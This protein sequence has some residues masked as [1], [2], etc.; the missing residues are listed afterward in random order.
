MVVYR[1]SRI[2]ED[3]L[4]ILFEDWIAVLSRCNKSLNLGNAVDCTNLSHQFP[5]RTRRELCHMDK[6]FAPSLLVALEFPTRET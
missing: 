3:Y 1:Y 4:S 6:F 5:I 2:N